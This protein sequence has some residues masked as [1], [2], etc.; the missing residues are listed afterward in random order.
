MKRALVAA[1]GAGVLVLTAPPAFAWND[2]VYTGSCVLDTASAV[3]LHQDA[4]A[5]PFY[6]FFQT[7]SPSSSVVSAA[8]SCWVTVNGA[9][10]YG[11][12]GGTMTGNNF[13]YGAAM[14]QYV[15][16]STDVLGVCWTVDYTGAGDT[17]PTASTC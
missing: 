8:V 11:L 15:W 4:W 3:P 1:L 10:V 17:T 2:S 9:A 16:T 13:Q 7:T 6:G 5:T 12:Y 14:A